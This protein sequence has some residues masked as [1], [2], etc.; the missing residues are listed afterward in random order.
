[1]NWDRESNGGPRPYGTSAR[2]MR[3]EQIVDQRLHR[4][5][6][7]RIIGG[8]CGGLA[9]SFGGSPWLYRVAFIVGTIATSGALIFLYP[10]LWIFLPTQ[11]RLDHR[12]VEAGPS[13]ERIN[14][15]PSAGDI[16]AEPYQQ[17]DAAHGSVRSEGTKPMD[18]LQDE[19]LRVS[20]SAVDTYQRWRERQAG[21][22]AQPN[23]DVITMEPEVVEPA[24]TTGQ[25]IEKTDETGPVTEKTETT[26]TQ[27]TS[28]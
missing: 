6:R 13:P 1:M 19:L 12:Y 17:T 7:E 20:D 24:G 4:S 11:S 14:R 2:T 21:K 16:A 9:E 22:P 25:V 10:V 18:K 23:S 27:N 15:L 8:V 3:K 28:Q 26:G 5:E